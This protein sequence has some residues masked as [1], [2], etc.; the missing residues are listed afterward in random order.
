MPGL[1]ETPMLLP[2]TAEYALRAMAWLAT[3]PQDE[4]VRARDLSQATGIPPH[5]LS[6]VLRRLVLADLRLV[7]GTCF[8]Q[9]VLKALKQ[10]EFKPG[11]YRNQ[12]VATW[13]VLPINFRLSQ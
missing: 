12:A 6:K 10:W 13:V 11:Y 4:P 9:D 1:A 5:Y 8:E 7:R 3:I 2:Q